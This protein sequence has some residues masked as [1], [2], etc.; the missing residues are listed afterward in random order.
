M[1]IHRYTS[2]QLARLS[3]NS[4]ASSPRT[5]NKLDSG[6]GLMLCKKLIEQN[7]G[8]IEAESKPDKGTVFTVKLPA[9]P[10]F[11]VN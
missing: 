7:N 9:F 6:V 4:R 2:E 8:S 10:Q 11:S 1:L 5:E 3:N